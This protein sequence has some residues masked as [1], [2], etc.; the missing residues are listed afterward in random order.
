MCFVK[1]PFVYT[2]LLHLLLVERCFG[3]VHYC[4]RIYSEDEFSGVYSESY[5]GKLAGPTGELLFSILD[6]GDEGEWACDKQRGIVRQESEPQACCHFSSCFV[7]LLPK[8]ELKLDSLRS[9]AQVVSLMC[10]GNTLWKLL[11]PSC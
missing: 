8:H 1:Q 9:G 10:Q 11:F 5:G 6:P 2:V 3:Y 4:Y 7:W